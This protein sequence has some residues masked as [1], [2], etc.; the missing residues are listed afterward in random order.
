MKTK[1]DHILLIITIIVVILTI[2]TLH[3]PVKVP[4]KTGKETVLSIEQVKKIFPDAQK[5]I[6]PGEKTGWITVYDNS[7]KHLGSVIL[8]SPHTDHITGYGGATPLLIGINTQEKIKDIILLENAESPGF[9]ENVV[10]TG[11][12]DKWDGTNWK[13]V[14]KLEVDTISGATMT[15]SS[16]KQTLIERIS[17]ISP[18]SA[19]AIPEKKAGFD[20]KQIGIIVIPVFGFLMCFTDLKKNTTLRY[21]LLVISI[22]YL[23][24]FTA[25]CFSMALLSAWAVNGIKLSTSI[26][27]LVLVILAV[28]V[29][30]FTGKNFYCFFVCPFGAMQEILNKIIPWKIKL[31]PKWNKNLRYIRYGLLVIIVAS[32]LLGLKVDPNNLEPFSAF[33]FT[34]AG[35]AALSIAVI[36]LILAAG[37]NRPWCS[38]GCSAGAIL[39]LLKKPA[40]QGTKA[41]KEQE[42]C[43][44][45]K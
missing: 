45:D 5:I 4:V 23:G 8:S 7:D 40:V 37:I 35:I 19:P 13:E 36:S 26:G 24:F 34:V 18:E 15:S 27:I 42:K 16:I 39:D 12:L 11:F 33:K 22:L 21:I 10:K 1:T 43:N 30:I 3:R 2:N 38:F 44:Y 32:L 17:I 14:A 28:L 9:V 20:W 25:S 41:K 29:P 6:S 31:S